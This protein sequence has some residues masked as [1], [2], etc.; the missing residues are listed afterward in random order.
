MMRAFISVVAFGAVV[1]FGLPA[2]ADEIVEKTIEEHHAVE[3]PV[4]KERV[5]EERVVKEPP[6]PVVQKRTETVTT[7]TGDNDNDDNDND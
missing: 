6:P 5:I 1:T 7:T 3:V 4:V 2:S